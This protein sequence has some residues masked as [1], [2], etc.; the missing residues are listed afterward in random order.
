MKESVQK[1]NN[2]PLFCKQSLPT[3]TYWQGINFPLKKDLQGLKGGLSLHLNGGR[4]GGPGFLPPPPL[5]LLSQ[6]GNR[7]ILVDFPFSDGLIVDA[8]DWCNDKRVILQ[9]FVKFLWNII[10]FALHVYAL[11]NKA[12]FVP[13]F[14]G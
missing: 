6:I 4:G 7:L 11:A 12:I 2:V 5:E 14:A 1:K 10:H 13:I 3:Q 9:S 8:F